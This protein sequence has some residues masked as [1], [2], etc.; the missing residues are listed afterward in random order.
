MH[1]ETIYTINSLSSGGEDNESEEIDED[2]DKGY[3]ELNNEIDGQV[4]NIYY[5]MTIT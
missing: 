4:S 5:T 3:S 1:E 2:F